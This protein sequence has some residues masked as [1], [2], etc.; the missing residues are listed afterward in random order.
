MIS[1][2]DAEET[3][4]F[5]ERHSKIHSETATWHE[6]RDYLIA[7]QLCL[8]TQSYSKFFVLANS[9]H[10]S[11]SRDWSSTT[12]ARPRS[13]RFTLKLRSQENGNWI[14]VDWSR[15]SQFYTRFTDPYSRANTQRVSSKQRILERVR[16]DAIITVILTIFYQENWG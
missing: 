1:A 5:A 14:K 9:I 2:E 16:N 10:R 4:P 15:E 7:C 3:T 8:A 11:L 12:K 6:R 13:K